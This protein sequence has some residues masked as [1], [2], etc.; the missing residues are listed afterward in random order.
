MSAKHWK[1]GI[2]G[3][4][5]GYSLSPLMH[6]AALKAAGLEGEYKEYPVKSEDL[7]YWLETQAPKLDGFNVTMPHK[8]EVFRWIKKHGEVVHSSNVDP[9]EAVNTV[10]VTNKKF[11]GYNTDGRGFY[12]SLPK[13]LN[14]KGGQ[15]LLLGAGG[16]A[17]A[18][19]VYLSEVAQ[20]ASLK[21]WNRH[22]ERAE[23]LA[24]KLEILRT[25]CQPLV[26]TKVELIDLK[27][28]NLIVNATSLGMNGEEE[29]PEKILG[30]LNGK[31]VV[32][33]LVYEP[34]ETGL[35]KTAKKQGCPTIMGK[36]MLINQGIEAFEIWTNE[37]FNPES[38]RE[39]MRKAIG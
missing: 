12:D 16:A 17:Q 22:P 11:F 28:I 26:F 7:E 15:V 30:Q 20:I 6:T 27:G 25:P 19:A 23:K 13:N 32:F 24:R 1:L 9:I 21:I 33:D 31:Q 29:V 8:E 3:W 37:R 35:I 39:V 18:V 14:L 36:E 2:I 34:E 10:K 5:L 38:L 4:P